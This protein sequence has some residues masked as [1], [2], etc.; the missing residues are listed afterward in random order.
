M[1]LAFVRKY[2]FGGSAKRPGRGGSGGRGRSVRFESLESRLLLSFDPSGTEQEVLFNLNRM[3]CNPQGELSVR[4]QKHQSA[5]GGRPGRG[6]GA[7][8]L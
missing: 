7:S 6:V 2:F 5:R 3:R 4:V 1:A 8:I